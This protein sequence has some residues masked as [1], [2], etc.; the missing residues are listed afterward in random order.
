MQPS[1]DGYFRLCSS[2]SSF[3]GTAILWCLAFSV[4][5]SEKMRDFTTETA[6]LFKDN[7]GSCT[8][9]KLIVPDWGIK[10][11]LVAM[12]NQ[13]FFKIKSLCFPAFIK[14]ANILSTAMF[15]WRKYFFHESKWRVRLWTL[16]SLLKGSDTDTRNQVGIG[17]S[18][19]PASPSSLA[20][21]FQTQFLEL[22]PRPIAGLKFSRL[23]TLSS[24]LLCTLSSVPPW[25]QTE[26]AA[27]DSGFSS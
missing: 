17:L 15:C 16:V 4:Y 14:D 22:I 24:V 9:G 2:I 20:T 25:E 26:G 21:Q 1:G 12:S 18:Y 6:L 27:M 13:H 23:C 3:R 8:E 11:T 10:L 5:V 7:I 19:R